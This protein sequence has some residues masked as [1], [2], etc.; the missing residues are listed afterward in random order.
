MDC[1][2]LGGLALRIRKTVKIVVAALVVATGP[3]L[4]ESAG[5]HEYMVACAGCHGESAMGMGP[6]SE[7]LNVSTPSLVD[8]TERND[9]V[10]PYEAV[11]NTIDGRDGL[12]AHGSP[13]PLWGERY[14]NSATSER[15]E[16]ADMVA[17]G[18]ILSLVLYLQSIQR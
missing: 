9:G 10:F 8:L 18:R 17:R 5:E 13:M 6:F 2:D 12:R 11:L 15:G 14:R 1:I 4:A 7:L 3:V 16:T